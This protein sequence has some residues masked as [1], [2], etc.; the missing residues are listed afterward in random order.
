LNEN[1]PGFPHDG[2]VST[3][4]SAAGLTL[5]HVEVVAL[6]VAVLEAVGA[7]RH[8]LRDAARSAAE[9]NEVGGPDQAAHRG[10]VIAADWK[11]E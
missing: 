10:V 4:A 2:G 1:V 11:E 3:I 9:G 5:E 7:K 6:V 8:A